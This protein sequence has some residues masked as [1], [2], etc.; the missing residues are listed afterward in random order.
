MAAGV[1][2]VLVLLVS[3][4]SLEAGEVFP[5]VARLPLIRRLVPATRTA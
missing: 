5:E 1:A 4:N 3:R 2:S